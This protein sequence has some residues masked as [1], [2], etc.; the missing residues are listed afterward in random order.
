MDNFHRSEIMG[1]IQVDMEVKEILRK[2]GSYGDSFN[3][4]LRRLLDVP[5]L[6][7]IL[8]RRGRYPKEREVRMEESQP[9]EE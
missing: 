1:T 8:R 2:K 4:I 5:P 9:A 6:P 7:P 3:D